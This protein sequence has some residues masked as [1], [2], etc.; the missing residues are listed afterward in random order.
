MWCIIT[1]PCIPNENTFFFFYAQRNN[2]PAAAF[3]QLFINKKYT[4][5]RT[6]K[7][8]SINTSEG[9]LCS[10]GSRCKRCSVWIVWDLSGW[11]SSE[12]GFSPR[13]RRKVAL[14]RC[15]FKVQMQSSEGNLHFYL[16]YLFFFVRKFLKLTVLLKQSLWSFLVERQR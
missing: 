2:M 15:S 13:N 5:E 6:N 7:D 12:A 14:K 8:A 11:R 1:E 4:E 3:K 16:F 10:Q 9:G